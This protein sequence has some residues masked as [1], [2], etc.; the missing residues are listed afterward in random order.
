MEFTPF[1]RKPY[2]VQAV[3]ITRDNIDEVAKWVGEVREDDG[4]LYILVDRRMV[5]GHFRVYPGYFMT[6]LGLNVRCYPRKVFN[7]LF[8]EEDEDMKPWIE[9][10]EQKS[11]YTR[12]TKRDHDNDRDYDEMYDDER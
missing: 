8:V 11:G 10:M 5:P 9:F 2:V 7:D 4:Q 3:E 6:K 12:Y 1:L